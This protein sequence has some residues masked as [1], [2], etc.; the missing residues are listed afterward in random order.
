MGLFIL[1]QAENFLVAELPSIEE[2]V[3]LLL[4]KVGEQVLLHRQSP[5]QNTTTTSLPMAV[6]DAIYQAAHTPAA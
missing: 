3:R 4:T 6:I 2:G 5:G 1:H